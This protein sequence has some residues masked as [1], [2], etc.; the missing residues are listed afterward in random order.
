MS[1]TPMMAGLTTIDQMFQFTL[2]TWAIKVLF[3][4][5]LPGIFSERRCRHAVHSV[6]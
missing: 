3:C 6:E 2:A 5:L 1:P 4:E